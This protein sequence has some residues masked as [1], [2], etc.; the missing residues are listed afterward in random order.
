MPFW[1]SADNRKTDLE[2]K[3]KEKV[4]E[5][6]ELQKVFIMKQNCG[7]IGHS[8]KKWHNT[9]KKFTAPLGLSSGLPGATATTR[10]ISHPPQMQLI[11]NTRWNV[12]KLSTSVRIPHSFYLYVTFILFIE[13]QAQLVPLE[14]HKL[15]CFLWGITVTC[16]N[17]AFISQSLRVPSIMWLHV[18]ICTMRFMT[19]DNNFVVPSCKEQW[20]LINKYNWGSEQIVKEEGIQTEN[21]MQFLK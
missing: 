16:S 5:G 14:I 21:R 13:I 4:K 3:E 2:N 9:L 17:C 8:S 11:Y 7:L 18:T 10:L 6:Y 20:G 12:V 19:Q 15:I 1:L